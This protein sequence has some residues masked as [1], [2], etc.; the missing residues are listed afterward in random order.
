VNILGHT[1]GAR[2]VRS[3]LPMSEFLSIV[4]PAFNEEQRI[5]ETIRAIFAYVSP[6]FRGYEIIVSDDGSSDA[7]VRIVSKLREETP[8]TLLTAGVNKGKGS[9]VRRGVAASTGDL[10]LVT[11]ADLSTPLAELDRLSDGIRAGADIAIGSRGLADSRILV[12]QPIHR[13]LLGRAFN[14][15]LRATL[16]PEIRDTQCGFKLFRGAVA[17]QLFARSFVGGF[18][19]DVEIL[20][21]ALQAGYRVVEVPVEWSHMNN[22]KVRVL[23]DAASM[24]ADWIRIVQWSRNSSRQ[25]PRLRRSEEGEP[26]MVS[27]EA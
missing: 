24:L 12:H 6:M 14:V 27:G 4:I 3:D 21:R 2:S 26:S 5:E 20:T 25:I 17:R 1:I 8:L 22:S 16:L 19:F 7:T 9:A 10:I 13:E 11:D 15:L 23:R 18:A